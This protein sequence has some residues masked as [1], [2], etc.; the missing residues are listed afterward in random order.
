MIVRV[1]CRSKYKSIKALAK[2]FLIKNCS[3]VEKDNKR[4][5]DDR[6]EVVENA[7]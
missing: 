3:L 1:G 5:I 4:Y 7:I 2:I 6:M